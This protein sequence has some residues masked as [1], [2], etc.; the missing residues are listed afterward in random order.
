MHLLPKS[1]ANLLSN[2]TATGLQAWSPVQFLLMNSW[3]QCE[4]TESAVMS[5]PMPLNA[6]LVDTV[7]LEIRWMSSSALPKASQALARACWS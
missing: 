2:F 4:W 6:E 1:I 7:R 3:K 5:V